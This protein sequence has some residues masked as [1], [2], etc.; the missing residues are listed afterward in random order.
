MKDSDDDPFHETG[1]RDSSR[2][3]VGDATA[4]DI[5]KIIEVIKT[6]F[7]RLSFPLRRKSK[8]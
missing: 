5:M 4:D 2:I 8:Y 3:T 1:E 7:N 6:L